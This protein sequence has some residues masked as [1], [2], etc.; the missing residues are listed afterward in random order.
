[1]TCNLYANPRIHVLAVLI[2]AVFARFC[3]AQETYPAADAPRQSYRPEQVAPPTRPDSWPGAAGESS[4]WTP[5]DQRSTQPSAK[6]A[7]LQPCR[8][9]RILARV[10]SVAVLESEV[11]G[12]VNELIEMNKD[13]IPPN[14]IEAQRELLIKQRLKRLIEEKMVYE[15]ARK[16]I[17]PEGWERVHEQLLDVF[18]E[19]QL[20]KLIENSGVA[21]RHELDRKLRSFGTS[22]DQEKRAFCERT[23]VQQWL[24]QQVGDDEEITCDRIIGYYH[25][26]LDEFRHPARAKWEELMVRF[27]DYQ[28]KALARDALARLGNQ[29]LSGAA[30]AETA[31]RGSAGLTASDGGARDWTTKGSLVCDELDRALFNLPIG[32]LSPII[33]G[34]LGFHIIR[35]TARE[36]ERITPFRDA[37]VEI[38]EKIVKEQRKKQL[39]EYMDKLAAKVPVW[40][41]FDEADGRTLIS[42]RPEQRF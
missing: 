23:L 15:D 16:T 6:P 37:Q 22:L 7:Q 32:Q 40:T 39:E 11:L 13:R 36:P 34:P 5:P 42:S 18:E 2:V 8:G 29:V 3:L 9:A 35:V 20:P 33:E 25:S 1:M 17:P 28:H 4:P 14:Q 26:H 38:R 31:K 24:R 21:D 19:T 41:I 27:S 30:F 10:G 12:A